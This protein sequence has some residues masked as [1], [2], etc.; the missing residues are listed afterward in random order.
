MLGT[1]Q[2]AFLSRFEET[3]SLPHHGVKLAETRKPP[4][5]HPPASSR[6]MLSLWQR[7]QELGTS[8]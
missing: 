4:C 5:A 8:L 6:E 3:S 7:R 2:E 1:E